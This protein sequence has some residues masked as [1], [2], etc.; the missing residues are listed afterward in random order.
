MQARDM[1][2]TT[3]LPLPKKAPAVKVPAK[4]VTKPRQPRKQQVNEPP[5]RF[6]IGVAVLLGIALLV[7]YVE[8]FVVK[9]KPVWPEGHT[10][11]GV[12]V[13]HYQKE[14]AWPKVRE[15]EI[16]FA[17]VKA[18]EGVSLKDRK[19]KENWEGAA[20]AGIIRGAYHFYLPYLDPE[21]QAKHFTAT[22]QLQSG[23]LPPVLDVEVRGRKPIAQLRKD[24]K[25]WLDYVE[26]AYGTKPIIYTGY[27]FYKDYLAGH[28]DSY[29]LWIAHYEVPRLSINKTN[30]R[31]LSFWQ[32]TDNGSIGGIEASVDCNVFYGS[33]R[34]L[35]SLCIP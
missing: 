21:K 15:S 34:D 19:F 3:K 26:N 10:I 14:I 25:V 27:H 4:R 12:D 6:W 23:D 29:P 9:P 24:L 16:T 30:T 35:K 11:Y 17:F 20:G 8:Y 33:M 2:T 28:F 31:K 7:F 22:V 18:T 13:S 5:K 32:H 1:A